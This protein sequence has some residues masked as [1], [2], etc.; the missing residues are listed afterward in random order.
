MYATFKSFSYKSG[1]EPYFATHDCAVGKSF[2]KRKELTQLYCVV[3]A[4]V[5]DKSFK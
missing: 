1:F 2:D 3:E 5:L 4:E